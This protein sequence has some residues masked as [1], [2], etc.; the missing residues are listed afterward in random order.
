MRSNPKA[1]W[2]IGD[3][4]KACLEVGLTCIKPKGGSHYKVGAA[5]GGKRYTIPAR[6][7]IKPIYIIK[8]VEFLDQEG[9]Q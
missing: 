5:S 8:L 9:A 6:R 2:Q 3:V 1:D 4:E 7:P